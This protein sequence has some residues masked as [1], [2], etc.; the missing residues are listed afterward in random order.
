MQNDSDRFFAL[1][2]GPGSGKTTLI[3]A[4]KAA[5]FA[6]AP[7]AGRGIIRDQMAIGGPA[8]PW[9][10]RALF[11][12]LM[13]SWEMRSWHAAHAEPGP[14]FFDRGVPDTIGYLRLCGLPV[15][16]HIM[17]AA[18]TFR[19]V[20]RVFIAPPWPQIF[21]QDEERKQTPDEAERT[22]QAVAGAYA[23]L[24]YELVSLPLAPVEERVRF[25][26]DA[27]GLSRT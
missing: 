21:T 4:L 17:S 19:Y 1:T 24:G 14:V 12:E 8:L 11:A 27:A 5:G 7:E 15:L 18:T 16:S 25:V 26:L 13:L 6:T 20:R 10:D 3:E 2:G 23:E 9:Q 22:F